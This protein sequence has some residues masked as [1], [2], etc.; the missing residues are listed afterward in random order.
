MPTDSLTMRVTEYIFDYIRD[1][2][3]STGESVPSELRTSNDLNI[4][5]GIVR[6]AFRSLEVAG[7]IEKEN[8]RPPRVGVL[9]SYFLT[10]LMLHALSTKQISVSQVLELR[11][12][13]E[14]QAAQTAARRRKQTDIQRLRAAVAGMKKSSEDP[15]S[16]VRYDLDFHSALNGATH[17]P[18]AEVICGA[19]HECMRESMYLGILIRRGKR[20]FLR[21]A[22]SHNLIVDAIEKGSASRAG[23]LMKKHFD[24]AKDAFHKDEAKPQLPKDEAKPRIR[25]QERRIRPAH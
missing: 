18:L 9:N 25:K 21:V 14:V 19:M 23:A 7:I 8:G 24:E 6:E 13:I 11:V 16:F 4:S 15:E 1:N 2:H 3:L 17:N 20:E 10:H 5:R 12:S 22:E